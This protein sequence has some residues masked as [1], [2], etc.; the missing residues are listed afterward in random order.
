MESTPPVEDKDAAQSGCAP[1]TNSRRF[2]SRNVLIGASVLGVGGALFFGWDWLVAA[3]VASVIV[4]V[5]PCLAMCALGLCA[6]RL[7]RKDAANTVSGVPPRE[8]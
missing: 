6:S 3:G 5:L 1:A 8:G 2:Y 4:G 7:G